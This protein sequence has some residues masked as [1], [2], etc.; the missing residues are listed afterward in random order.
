MTWRK[1]TCCLLF[2]LL[3][4]LSAGSQYTLRPEAINYPRNTYLAQSQTWS[5][6]QDE[7]GS[8]FF[9]NNESLLTYNGAAWK[10]YTLPKNQIVRSVAADPPGWVYTGGL[11]L[12]GQW[13]H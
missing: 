4:G 11:G 7:N 5:I 6:T 12:F 2:L 8:M 1:N 13:W 3:A 9:G 10:I